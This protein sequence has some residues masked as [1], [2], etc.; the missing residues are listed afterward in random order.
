MSK[1]LKKISKNKKIKKRQRENEKQKG[2]APFVK[3]HVVQ[4]EVVIITIKGLVSLR[5]MRVVNN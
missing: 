2:Y 5:G 4:D 3:K 1:T